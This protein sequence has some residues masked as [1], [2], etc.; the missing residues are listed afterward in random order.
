MKAARTYSIHIK[1]LASI[2]ASPAER[3]ISAAFSS[4]SP[5]S[6]GSFAYREDN[7]NMVV[8]LPKTVRSRVK[9]LLPNCSLSLSNRMM[10]IATL[11]CSLILFP[12]HP[13]F[14]VVVVSILQKIRANKTLRR[15]LR[16]QSSWLEQR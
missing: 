7:V 1:H 3:H 6:L 16:Y 15:N 2:R 12:F 14:V 13:T 9:P 10:M 8:G 11:S 4:W 5:E